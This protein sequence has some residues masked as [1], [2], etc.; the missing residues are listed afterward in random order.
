MK[1][2][3]SNKEFIQ[4]FFVGDT[5]CEISGELVRIKLSPDWLDVSFKEIGFDAVWRS[6]VPIGQVRIIRRSSLD[7]YY[8]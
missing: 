2:K 3:R 7:A 8:D 1:K 4:V 6:I 5:T